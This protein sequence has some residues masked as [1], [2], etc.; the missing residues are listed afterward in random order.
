MPTLAQKFNPFYKEE[1]EEQTLAQKFGKPTKLS[2]SGPTLAEK[3][4]T[5]KE[6]ELKPIFETK[7][8]SLDAVGQA[9]TQFINSAGF[10]LPG[11]MLGKLGY[12][13]P[14]PISTA[15]KIG[16]G[17]G[18][19]AGFI[20]G[21]PAKLGG[22]VASKLIP[23]AIGATTKRTIAKIMGKGAIRLGI[24]SAT[25]TPEEGLFA[26]KERLKQFGSGAITGT[27]FGGLSF[28]PSTAL[29]MAT[30][31][32]INGIP[33]TM[34]EDSFEEQVFNYGLGAYFGRKGMSAKTIVEQQKQLEKLIQ[35]GVEGEHY[36]KIMKENQGFLNEQSKYVK[37]KGR[38][39]RT[40]EQ[41][42]DSLAGR[43]KPFD[44]EFQADGQFKPVYRGYHKGVMRERLWKTLKSA[45]ADPANRLRTDDVSNILNRLT[46][47]KSMNK[48]SDKQ[49]QGFLNILE[50]PGQAPDVTSLQPEKANPLNFWD[51][52]LRPAYGVLKKMGL[53]DFSQHGMTNTHFT[54]GS[55]MAQDGL[56]DRVIFNNWKKAIGVKPAVSRDIARWLDGKVTG[57]Y[58]SKNYGGKVLPV[59]KQMRQWY[60]LKLEGINRHRGRYGQ[61]PIM[62][63]KN[64]YTHIFDTMA[65]ELREP[66]KFHLPYDLQDAM[67]FIT[68]KEKYNPFTKKRTGA[69][70]YKYDIWNALDIYSNRANWSANDDF[71]R[72][73]HR[74]IRFVTASQKDPSI[75]DEVK[76]ML[77]NTKTNLQKFVHEY[78]GRPG[79]LD[80]SLRN[81][82]NSFNKIL[83]NAGAPEG[84]MKSISE[85]SNFLTSAIY[86]TQMAY[87][88]KLAI[89]NLGQ[90]SLIIGQTGFKPLFK[91]LS[92][93]RTPEVLDLLSKSNVVKSRSAAFAPEAGKLKGFVKSGMWMYQ[94]ADMKNVTDAFLSGYYD[95]IAKGMSKPNA[96]K[97]G[98][99]VAG[100]SQFIYLKG[101]RSGLARG[102]GVSSTLGKPA[103]IFTTWSANYI[104]FLIASSAPENRANLLKYLGTGAG[105]V[106]LS[107]LAGV[108]G[109]NYV[110]FNS[111]QA[112]WNIIKKG[113]LPISGIT[114]GVS[115]T[116]PKS[117]MPQMV[118]DIQ[119]G[120]EG[121]ISD[122]LF[123]TMKE[124][125]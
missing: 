16:S 23:R 34:R 43:G 109:A 38:Y 53:G 27:A 39:Y 35:G 80:S 97:R 6:E 5:P 120:V 59:A 107:A 20:A 45:K 31:A 57:D 114:S 106:A 75:P 61:D 103:S 10:G 86:G 117:L 95:G 98:D 69:Q 78:T 47:K 64:Y 116:N 15:G 52:T 83:T 81:T 25:M 36:S 3:Y 108:K 50:N 19:L 82:M 55:Q 100:L 74:Y 51:K 8:P 66:N 90:H 11:Y 125:E 65:A 7:D 94:K 41:L 4:G 119:K 99:Q 42:L 44:Y 21:G 77:Y 26:P 67:K 14:D 112:I 92:A 87:R 29:R 123:Y 115:I 122:V 63:R 28:I 22:K 84:A 17:V 72:D 18:N 76:G 58:L 40:S 101:N 118:K 60:D 33:S 46:T 113:Q 110:G 9:T 73:T 32:G 71:M 70:G 1:E 121:D 91:A 85:V 24:A 96:I 93:K 89:R 13:I 104:E 79:T 37:G 105:V 30:M 54:K 68:P 56:N 2:V 49:L 48:F 12:E 124:D 111:P 102:L 62:P 88:P